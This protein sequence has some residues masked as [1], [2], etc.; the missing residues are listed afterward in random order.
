MIRILTLWGESGYLVS[1]SLC[2][3][4][5]WLKVHWV[6]SVLETRNDLF[7]EK[8]YLLRHR[9]SWQLDKATGKNKI[10]EEVFEVVVCIRLTTWQ[11]GENITAFR[12]PYTREDSPYF[13][14]CGIP[15][16]PSR[17][18][19]SFNIFHP[20]EVSKRSI[21]LPHWLYWTM[22]GGWTRGV[23]LGPMSKMRHYRH[24]QSNDG[25]YHLWL[26]FQTELNLSQFLRVD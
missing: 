9:L 2:H 18:A 16:I 19:I 6:E 22:R 3:V 12:N 24:L 17:I 21:R 11:S 8:N 4:F 5:R 25:T 1:W 10:R 13:R 15:T 26:H 14:S 23:M 20:S 7:E